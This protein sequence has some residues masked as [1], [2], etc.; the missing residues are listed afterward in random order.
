M[1]ELKQYIQ[2][3][4]TVSAIQWETEMGADHGVK[5]KFKK[6]PMNPD[7]FHIRNRFG[8]E[9]PVVPGDWIIQFNDGSHE[10]ISNAA[11]HDLYELTPQKAEKCPTPQTS[12]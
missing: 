12:A 5:N 11:F 6:H 3:P 8:Q 9:K 2:K 4:I 10:I 7:S 1:S